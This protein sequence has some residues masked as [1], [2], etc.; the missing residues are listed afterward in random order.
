MLFGK[1]SGN[2]ERFGLQFDESQGKVTIDP[3]AEVGLNCRFVGPAAV[4][5]SAT[6]SPE[7]TIGPET[8][9][10]RGA[11]IGLGVEV[12]RSTVGER[13]AIKSGTPQVYCM[14]VGD[15]AGL[16]GHPITDKDGPGIAL[17]HV[18]AA[19]ASGGNISEDSG[20]AVQP[21]LIE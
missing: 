17:R 11:W 14:L 10:H 20:R 21:F 15:H 16:A 6:I 8:T 7:S 2:L 1:M 4:G 3:T 18:S 13:A 5:A 19:E 9:I 12:V